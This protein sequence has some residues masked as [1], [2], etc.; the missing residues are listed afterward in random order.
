ML[1]ADDFWCYSQFSK[2]SGNWNLNIFFQK[3][4]R[5]LWFVSLYTHLQRKYLKKRNLET[6]NRFKDI[7][8]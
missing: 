6:L 8:V 7:K 2:N 1:G 3:H 5:D 4:D